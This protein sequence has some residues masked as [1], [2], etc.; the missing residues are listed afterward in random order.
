VD[1]RITFKYHPNL[2]ES[3]ILE[4]GERVCDCCGKTVSIYYGR[5]YCKEDVNCL[6][7]DCV[8]SGNAARKFNGGFIQD[9]ESEKIIDEEK[10]KELFERTPGYISWQGEYWLVCCKDFCAYIGEVG[11]KELE[12]MGIADE[13]FLEY[14]ARGE[15]GNAREYLVKGGIMAGYLFQC[16]HCGKYHLWVD[17]N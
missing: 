15:Y 12:V 7:L 1:N 6:C 2:Y 9:G 5:M 14:D 10:K 4:K 13:V 11:T 16:L 3:D 17:A 8:S